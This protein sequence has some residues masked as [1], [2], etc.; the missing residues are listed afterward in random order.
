[1]KLRPAAAL[2]AALGCLSFSPGSP[3]MAQQK[4]AAAPAGQKDCA[5][6]SKALYAQA[7]A[8]S[9]RGKQIIPREFARV[10]ANLDEYCDEGDFAK[11][12]ISIDWM[13]TCLKNF[14]KNY[15]LGFCSRQKSYFCALDPQSD[16]C[17][18]SPLINRP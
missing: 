7:E 5:A 11:A 2:L 4:L 8:L 14:T 18:Q 1:M 13:N 12:R 17:L 10:A 3:V 15:N 16:A 9:K 6:T